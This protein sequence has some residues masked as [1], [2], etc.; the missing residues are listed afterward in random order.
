VRWCADIRFKNAAPATEVDI[1]FPVTVM[2]E[3]VSPSNHQIAV[4]IATQDAQTSEASP[5]SGSKSSE[6]PVAGEEEIFTEYGGRERGAHI[7]SLDH[8]NGEKAKVLVGI[9]GEAGWEKRLQSGCGQ[10][11]GEHQNVL[12]MGLHGERMSLQEAA[13]T[14]GIMIARCGYIL[15]PGFV[16][17]RQSPREIL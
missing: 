1:C 15:V 4:S 9:E 14:H 10:G 7:A 3:P 2:C 12:E 17:S 6:D 13:R 16:V 8:G 5:G 11:V